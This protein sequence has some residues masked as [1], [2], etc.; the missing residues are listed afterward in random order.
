MGMKADKAARK[1]R[2]G[3]I[4]TANVSGVTPYSTR[5][6]SC[7]GAV[8]EPSGAYSAAS[9]FSRVKVQVRTMRK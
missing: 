1:G 8:P 5:Y 4:R 2:P 3:G 6:K 9:W 7:R